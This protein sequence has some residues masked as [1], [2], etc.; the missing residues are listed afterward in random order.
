MPPGTVPPFR[1][2]LR[3]AGLRWRYSNPPPHGEEWDLSTISNIGIQFVPHR[4][5]ITS[6]L[7]SQ[8]GRWGPITVLY[9]FIWDCV[10]SS[11]PLT[12]RRD[13]GGSIL[14]RLNTELCPIALPN[15]NI[16]ARTA[17]KT[18][19]LNIFSIVASRSHR[20][21]CTGNIASKSNCIAVTVYRAISY[22]QLLFSYLFHC[23]C[24]ISA[25]AAV[26]INSHVNFIIILL[27]TE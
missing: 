13:Y 14:T 10:P 20:A 4:N 25:Y 24:A 21:D 12:T 18:S 3:L 22:Q 27:L 7:Q 23:C 8:P 11:S 16:S 26:Y 15:Y 17:E 1:R 19:F 9:R 2:L 5:H 6:P